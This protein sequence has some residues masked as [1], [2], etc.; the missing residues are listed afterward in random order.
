MTVLWHARA[1]VSAFSLTLV[2]VASGCF[3]AHGREEPTSA[4]APVEP[5]SVGPA[6]VAPVCEVQDRSLLVEVSDHSESTEPCEYGPT[7]GWVREVVHLA[8]GLEVTLD[9]C[10]PG[11]TCDGSDVCTVRIE[12]VRAPGLAL[13]G[14]ITGWIEPGFVRLSREVSCCRGPGCFCGVPSTVLYVRWA[15]PA[16]AAPDAPPGLDELSFARGE[17]LCGDAVCGDAA[18][19]L[20]AY[21]EPTSPGADESVSEVVR[22]GETKE[23]GSTGLAVHLVGSAHDPCLDEPADALWVAWLLP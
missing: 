4:A 21:V 18:F 13:E 22:P 1:Q 11:D 16:S 14:Y 10:T 6:T 17:A 15:N 8:E 9:S 2:A 12:G 3:L 7:E 20:L 23:L 5:D 19:E